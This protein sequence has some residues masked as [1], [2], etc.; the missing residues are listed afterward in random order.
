MDIIAWEQI[1]TDVKCGKYDCLKNCSCDVLSSF[2]L[3]T[4]SMSEAEVALL[5]KWICAQACAVT[6]VPG[7]PGGGNGEIGTQDCLDQLSS[8]L[9]TEDRQTALAVMR[10]IYKAILATQPADPILTTLNT[11]DALAGALQSFCANPRSAGAE[12]AMAVICALSGKV[13]SMIA[14]SKAKGGLG[15]TVAA[16]AEKVFTPELQ[17]KMTACCNTRQTSPTTSPV[18]AP[19][20]PGGTPPNRQDPGNSP[21]TAPG[22]GGGGVLAMAPIR[23]A[24]R[25]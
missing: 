5:V 9:C 11:L 15:A 25:Q 3:T 10:A 6:T 12:A 2:A 22:G 16:A 21:T 19:P 13:T 14:Q 1:R 4:R 8:Y 20:G 23:N 17:A 24:W 18:P 7:G